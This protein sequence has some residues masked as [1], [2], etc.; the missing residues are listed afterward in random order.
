M[1]T[2]PELAPF[3]VIISTD[4]LRQAHRDLGTLSD[5]LKSPRS[6]FRDPV[7]VEQAA[8][9]ILE[10]TATTKLIT[11]VV[12]SAV[13]EH[14]RQESR[15]RPGADTRYRRVTRPRLSLLGNPVKVGHR[16]RKEFGQ[17]F[18]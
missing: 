11:V 1:I 3:Y 10:K 18:R 9:A 4:R 8:Q 16:F 12:E 17:A 6:R 5:R 2:S 15:G 13:E 7:A 14:F